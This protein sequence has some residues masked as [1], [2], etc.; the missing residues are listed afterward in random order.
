MQTKQPSHLDHVGINNEM[1]TYTGGLF[2]IIVLTIKL[3][4]IGTY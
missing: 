1:H 4:C 2:G 3:K